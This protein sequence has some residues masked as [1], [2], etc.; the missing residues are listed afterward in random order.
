MKKKEKTFL[1]FNTELFTISK[2]SFFRFVTNKVFSKFRF[3][4]MKV[5]ATIWVLWLMQDD[6][7]RNRGSVSNWL[8]YSVQVLIF[9]K[10]HLSHN[11]PV[12]SN[13]HPNGFFPSDSQKSEPYLRSYD[14]AGPKARTIFRNE[15]VSCRVHEQ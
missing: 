12:F 8:V 6:L 4:R 11:N 15:I 3:F 7:K 9:N 14:V 2:M 5:S 13:L 10:C 1:F